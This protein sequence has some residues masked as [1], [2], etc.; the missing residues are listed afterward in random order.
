YWG[1]GSGPY[2]PQA[3]PSGQGASVSDWVA[4]AP[5]LGAQ[6]S[7]CCSSVLFLPGIKGSRLYLSDGSG[8]ER[9]WEPVGD[10]D[11]ENLLFDDDGASIRDVYVKDGDVIR[12]AY[13]PLAGPNIY[14]SFLSD[15]DGLASDGVISGW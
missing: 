2:H 10:R 5:W 4:F 8:E 11:I 1:H 15:L 9:L 14:K 6:P 13:V 12:E 3:N 7:K